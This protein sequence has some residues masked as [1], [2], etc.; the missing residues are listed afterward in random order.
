MLA[1]FCDPPFKSA[2]P[3]IAFNVIPHDSHIPQKNTGFFTFKN[4]WAVSVIYG[5]RTHASPT[6]RGRGNSWNLDR[7][8]IFEF[9]HSF[10][11]EFVSASSVEVAIFDNFNNFV[12][13]KDGNDVKGLVTPDELVDILCWVKNQEPR[14]Q[15]QPQPQS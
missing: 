6:E 8:P 2:V 9:P 5:D 10:D 14:T 12:P 11:S 4:R 13:F 1:A 7:V 15:P 3:Y